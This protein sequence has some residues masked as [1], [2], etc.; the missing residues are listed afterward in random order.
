M[1]GS[2]AHSEAIGS[3]RTPGMVDRCAPA[4]PPLHGLAPPLSNIRPTYFATGRRASR[5]ISIA[6]R[7]DE[8]ASSSSCRDRSSIVLRVYAFVM[9]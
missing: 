6:A 3:V 8:S 4:R 5:I 9:R 1:P 2:S 7:R